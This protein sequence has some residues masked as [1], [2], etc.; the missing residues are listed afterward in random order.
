VAAVAL[1]VFVY[2]LYAPRHAPPLFVTLGT[3]FI[4]ML[5]LFKHRTN[6]ERLIAGNE[7]RINFPR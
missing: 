4:S 7:P 5:I 6:V 2:I 3:V 1:P